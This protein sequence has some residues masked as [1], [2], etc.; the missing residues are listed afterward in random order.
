MNEQ[1]IFKFE[2][3]GIDLETSFWFNGNIQPKLT[4]NSKFLDYGN[5][6]LNL[7]EVRLL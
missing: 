6:S 4:L 7:I 5:L 2:R 3:R 1:V